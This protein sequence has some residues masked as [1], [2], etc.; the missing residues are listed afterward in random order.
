MKKIIAIVAILMF[1]FAISGCQQ[2]D[3]DAKINDLE[4]RVSNLQ[5]SIRDL[6]MENERLASELK[7]AKARNNR[8]EALI[9]NLEKR[10]EE[11]LKTIK[12]REA[13]L[14]NLYKQARV[15]IDKLV[16]ELRS[17]GFEKPAATDTEQTKRIGDGIT[18]EKGADGKP[19]KLVIAGRVLFPSGEYKL[20]SPARRLF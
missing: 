20:S 1:A 8:D 13:M 5:T 18:L 14:A 4:V 7:T 11:L 10:I 2:K 17:A 3:K 6:K 9:A 12:E 15:D 19:T 16:E